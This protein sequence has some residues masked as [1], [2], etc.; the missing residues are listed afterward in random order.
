M[1]TASETANRS[2]TL[3][4]SYGEVE[5]LHQF[6]RDAVSDLLGERADEELIS[7]IILAVHEAFTNIIRHAYVDAKKEDILNSLYPAKKRDYGRT[8]RPWRRI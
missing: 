5:K 3:K 4:C 6:L 1:G 2:L 7:T 8:D